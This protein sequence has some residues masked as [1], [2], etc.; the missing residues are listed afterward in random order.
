M[1]LVEDLARAVEVEVVLG[2]VGPRQREDPV[3][4]GADDAVLGGGRR[5]L[6]EPRELAAGGLEHLLGQVELLEPRP[7]LVD[8]GLL[9][10]AS[11]S[12]SWIAFSCWRRKNS[13]WPFSISDWTCD[14]IFG[15]EL[16]DLELAVE[17]Q[18]DLAQPLLD[19]DLL[20]QLLLLLGL[21]PERRGDEVA[22]RAR[23]VDVR[24]GE[25]QLLGEVR[26]EAD[27]AGE[28]A[29]D[30]ARQRLDL[31]RLADDVGHVLELADEVRLVLPRL[32]EPDP[33]EPLDEDAQ[34]PVGD[35]DHLVDDRGRADLVQVV[36]AGLL[37][38]R[39]PDGDEREHPVAR[40]D[41]VDQPHRALLADR[42][43]RHRVGE[44]D[45]LLQRE[46]RQPRGI[47]VGTP[48]RLDARSSALADD[49]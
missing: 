16:E 4:V 43:R 34:R 48:R 3:E 20:E 36:P 33:L 5:Q 13:R 31:G 2:G 46:D 26:G 25:L 44:D 35:L 24:G 23:V 38:L 19:V 37:G 32:D 7:Q 42:E 28:E 1:V 49:R 11:P 27:D 8:L 21:E 14:W 39:V 6:L 9:V 29:L 17:D 30:V 10:V 45:R 40:D 47:S 22:E 12:S 18:R 15:A 41:V